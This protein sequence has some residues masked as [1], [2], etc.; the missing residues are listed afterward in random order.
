MSLVMPACASDL[1][2]IQA[3]LASEGLPAS[4]LDAGSLST[5]IVLR[6]EGN[7]R[8]VVGLEL[9]GDIALLRSL[10]VPKGHRGHGH[11]EALVDAAEARARVSGVQSIYLLTTTADQFFARRGYRSIPRDAAP[12]AIRRTT[13]FAGLCPSSAIVMLK[14]LAG[15]RPLNVLFLCTGNS[16]RSILAE[17][18]IN[19]LGSGRFVGFS[20]GSFPTGKVNPRAIK[21]LEQQNLP[22][23]NLRSKSWDEFAA[24]DSAQL[25]V[26]ITVCDNAAGEACPVWPGRPV[27]AHWGL[28]D[29]AAAKGTE[30]ERLV[31]FEDTYRALEKRVR[32]FIALPIASLNRRTL[33]ERLQAIGKLPA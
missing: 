4:D 15:Q 9:H 23:G 5:F 14:Q 27:A 18:L 8:G 22:T 1:P 11:G 17:S 30:A 3:L 6:D 28:P 2:Q 20:A 12:D 13:Q 29:P 32:A 21:L 33:V 24:A 19:H 16:A 7:L 26:I 31:A 25:D 10:V